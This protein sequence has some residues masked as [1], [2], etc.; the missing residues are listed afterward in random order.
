[1]ALPPAGGRNKKD[2][3]RGL[4]AVAKLVLRGIRPLS[5]GGKWTERPPGGLF[6]KG[7][8]PPGTPRSLT[9][10]MASAV[11]QPR[12]CRGASLFLRGSFRPPRGKKSRPVCLT[13]R[14]RGAIVVSVRTAAIAVAVVPVV[15]FELEGN[16]AYRYGGRLF[17]MSEGRYDQRRKTDEHQ[18]VCK[19]IRVSYHIAH[20]L[21]DRGRF[22]GNAIAAPRRGPRAI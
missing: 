6:T 20:P 8:M 19:H 3:L 5:T 18:R 21:F 9:Q 11:P 7:E 1:M 17:L 22:C 4:E 15:S 2:R 12:V 16:A 10:R 13:K 14:L